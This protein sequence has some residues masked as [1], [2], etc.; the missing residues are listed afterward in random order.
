MRR[1]FGPKTEEVAGDWRR[2]YDEEIHK[3]Y[4]SS[5]IITM[6]KSRRMEWAEHVTRMSEMINA[7]TILVGEPE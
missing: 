2:L 7:Y 3:L 6:I 4:S 1:K 5:S